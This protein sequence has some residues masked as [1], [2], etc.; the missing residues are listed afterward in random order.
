MNQSF[1][2][3]MAL[4][5]PGRRQKYLGKAIRAGATLRPDAFIELARRLGV[6]SVDAR[7]LDAYTVRLDLN[8]RSIT[9]SVLEKG[10]FQSDLFAAFAANAPD[11]SLA[12]VNVG[13]NV[14]TTCLNAHHAGYRDIVAFEPVAANFALLSENVARLPADCRVEIHRMALGPEAGEGRIF[15]NPGST[16]R[17]SL[18]RD[19]GHGVETVP[20][21]TL[22]AVAPRR[23]A[24]LWIDAEGFEAQILRGGE[25]F[26]AQHCRALCLE[27]TP[28][29]LSAADLDLIDAVAK[30]HFRRILG[31]DGVA[32]KDLRSIRQIREGAQADVIFLP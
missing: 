26:L 16:G 6:T 15:I 32:A 13:A 1:A 9:E 4:L 14:G 11:R 18:V 29:L 7:Y 5:R 27:I 23:P 20:I 28:A 30:R 3:L 25:A 12:F 17:H 19:F 22:D 24:V 31:P 2:L 8:G 10:D 21:R